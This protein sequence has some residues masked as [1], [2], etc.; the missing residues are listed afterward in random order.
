MK[1][2]ASST[3]ED[4][5]KARKAFNEY[6]ETA[7]TPLLG[8]S[9]RELERLNFSETA[10]RIVDANIRGEYRD[11][12]VKLLAANISFYG[13]NANPIGA[14]ERNTT[15]PVASTLSVGTCR[16]ASC[17]VPPLLARL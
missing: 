2:K 16:S 8:L 4:V 9:K 12:A 6:F 10:E 13:Q 14:P 3:Y 7:V 17:A 1:D 5:A 11:R 15:F